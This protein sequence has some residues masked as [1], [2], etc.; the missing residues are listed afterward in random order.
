MGKEAFR[1]RWAPGSSLA[2]HDLLL[3]SEG[4]VILAAV[5]NSTAS[6]TASAEAFGKSLFKR[7]TPTP[8][9]LS[10]IEHWM[11]SGLPLD[12]SP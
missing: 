8:L 2:V 10:A 7:L 11:G 3:G 9:A 6:D 1:H 4:V 5:G 12:I